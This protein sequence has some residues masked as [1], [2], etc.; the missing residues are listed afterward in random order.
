M[1]SVVLQRA[2]KDFFSSK[3]LFLSLA[4]F[5]VSV[6]ILTG[7]FVY[8]SSE[9]FTL[10]TQG[11][12]SG[13]FS[14]I[15]E[16]AYPTLAWLLT[17][18]VVHWF[19]MTLF[20]AVGGFSVVLLSLVIAVITVGLLTPYIAKTVKRRWY[21]DI[22]DGLEEPFLSSLWKMI[23]IFLK[24][25]LLLLLMLPFL[26]LPFVNFMIFQ[27]PFFY[28]FY[29]LMLHDL[30]SIGICE[31]AKEVISRNRFT[32]VLSILVFFL[33]SLIPLFGLLLQV[34]FIIYLTHF[35][36]INSRT[37]VSNSNI[38]IKS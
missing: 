26:L 32:L 30:Q 3:F 5:V 22:E 11:A 15:D 2:L 35:I 10:L 23:A 12:N 27:I 18:S 24:F 7:I 13:D 19:I 16:N 9:L 31:D 6:L 38:I 20:V 8:G 1:N 4:P 34:F 37:K 29:K 21:Q 25:I 17:F 36:L 33:L 28:L 14:F